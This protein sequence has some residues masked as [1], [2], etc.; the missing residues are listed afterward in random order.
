M[1][2]TDLAGWIAMPARGNVRTRTVDPARWWIQRH[3][4]SRH[5]R[6]IYQPE[7]NDSP[8]RGP[9]AERNPRVDEDNPELGIDTGPR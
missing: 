6:Q 5:W 1:A 8:S 2:D 7:E 9:A 3:C 4:S